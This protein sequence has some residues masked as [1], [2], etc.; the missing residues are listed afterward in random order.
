[1]IIEDVLWM[2]LAVV[3]ALSLLPPII[4]LTAM[5]WNFWLG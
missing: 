1:M 5:W 2:A 3:I 4:Y